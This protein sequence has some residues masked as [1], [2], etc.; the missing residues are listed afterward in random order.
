MPFTVASGFN[1]AQRHPDLRVHH[2]TLEI[3]VQS[4][5]S[6]T[7]VRKFRED[8]SFWNIVLRRDWAREVIMGMC[9]WCS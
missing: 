8:L 9:L 3:E 2:L 1:L 5:Q 7:T 6:T 4:G